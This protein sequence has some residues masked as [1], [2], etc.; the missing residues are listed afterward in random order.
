MGSKFNDLKSLVQDYISG[1]TS[2]SAD[3]IES[4]CNE[5][6]DDGDI[7]TSQY[8]YVFDLIQELC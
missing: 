5:Y 2:V 8:D 1:T 3:E 6:Y 4:S 7:S